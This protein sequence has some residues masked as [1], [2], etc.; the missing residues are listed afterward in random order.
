MDKA[1]QG[2]YGAIM[3]D[4]EKD[5]TWRVVKK[6]TARQ[7]G[8]LVEVTWYGRFVLVDEMELRRLENEHVAFHVLLFVVFVVVQTALC[9]LK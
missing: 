6:R 7:D 4:H 8:I 3:N 9:F 5:V 1:R 2:L